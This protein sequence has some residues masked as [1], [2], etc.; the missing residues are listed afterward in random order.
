[1]ITCSSAYCVVRNGV[2]TTPENAPVVE[3]DELPDPVL[4]DNP[5]ADTGEDTLPGDALTSNTDCV[6][7]AISIVN[8]VRP[9]GKKICITSTFTYTGLDTCTAFTSS[10]S[11]NDSGA[12]ITSFKVHV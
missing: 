6:G 2:N 1:V 5:D 10:V 7:D 11:M 12:R 9:F 4:A 8:Q 3:A